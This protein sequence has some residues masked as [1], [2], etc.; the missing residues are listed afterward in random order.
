LSLI[1]RERWRR[2]FAVAAAAAIALALLIAGYR[3]ELRA[4][5]ANI[6]AGHE[7]FGDVFSARNLPL[8]IFD[9]MGGGPGTV[10]QI[11]V[12][13][14]FLLLGA[15]TVS[16]GWRIVRLLEPVR[17]DWTAREM[18]LLAIASLLFPA[19]FFTAQ[20]IAYRCI[21]LLLALPGLVHLRSSI[22]Q[23]ALRRWLTQMIAVCLVMTWECAI[24]FNIGVLLKLSP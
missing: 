19:C 24:S 1:L 7:Y 3:T 10:A 4:A 16:R 14:L 8:G 18:A 13:A 22:D 20:N 15:V 6:P 5:L 23:P 17:I 12:P 11:V 21:Y 2:G 9:L